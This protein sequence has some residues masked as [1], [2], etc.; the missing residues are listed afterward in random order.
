MPV[1]ALAFSPKGDQLAV[2]GYG[3]VTLWNIA[4]GELVRRIGGLPERIL[5]IAWSAKRNMLAIAGGSPA[6]WGTV[7]LIDPRENFAVKFL[8]DLPETALTVAFSPDGTRLAAGAGDR[9]VR[10]F[11]VASGRETRVLRQHAD[12][13]QSVAF[14]PDGAR[15]VSASRDRT[16]RVS[17]VER[18]ELE[19]TYTGHDAALIG[20]VFSPTGSTVLSAARG[21]A[22]HQWEV[23][24]GE[25]KMEMKELTDLGMLA[26]LR[27]G[28]LTA[29]AAGRV[30]RVHQLSDRQTLFTLFGHRDAVASF[31]VAPDGGTFASG[32]F[33]GEVCV[34]NLAC[35]TWTQRFVASPGAQAT[36]ARG[37]TAR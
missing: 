23:S 15:L 32:S 1:A 25:R 17:N 11:D 29:P 31:A 21:S 28:L 36:E 5:S 14:S 3:E 18:G 27:A 37:I 2:A 16:A 24:S 9:T 26:M 34:W 6:Q 33:D 35:G 22:V 20:A 4:D 7:A 30:V 19:T 10:L 13:V 8:C 12:W